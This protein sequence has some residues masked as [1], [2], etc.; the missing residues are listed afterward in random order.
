[1]ARK[2]KPESNSPIVDIN[3]SFWVSWKIPAILQSTE[4][5]QHGE[6]ILASQTFL[7]LLTRYSVF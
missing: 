4:Y 3:N 1:M 6:H 7:L 2:A 5:M